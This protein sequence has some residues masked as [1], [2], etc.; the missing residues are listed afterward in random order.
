VAVIA[1]RSDAE[2]G[3]TISV[4]GA[5][6]PVNEML[7]EFFRRQD[8]RQLA[9][10]SFRETHK[11]I[12][13]DKKTIAGLVNGALREFALRAPRASALV[14]LR[15]RPG[16]RTSHTSNLLT[17]LYSRLP[18]IRAPFPPF[19]RAHGALWVH[20]QDRRAEEGWRRLL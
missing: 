7:T 17:A 1:V 20:Q 5:S 2:H 13:V 15:L 3:D 19:R 12:V 10:T 14:R 4:L 8:V 9:Q 18:S 16:Q 11:D 6:H